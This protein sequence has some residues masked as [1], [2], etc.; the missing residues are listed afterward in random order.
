MPDDT[1][2]GRMMEA[3][4]THDMTEEEFVEHLDHYVVEL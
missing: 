2:F 3:V 4:L 1:L